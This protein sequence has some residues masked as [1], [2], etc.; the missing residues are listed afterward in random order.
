MPPVPLLSRRYA[1]AISA[2]AGEGSA[3]SLWWLHNNLDNPTTAKMGR[4][5]A[6]LQPILA[7]IDGVKGTVGLSGLVQHMFVSVREALF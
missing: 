3:D 6:S 4:T 5:V 1:A 7:D 2:A